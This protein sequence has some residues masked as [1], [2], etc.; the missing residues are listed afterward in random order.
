MEAVSCSETLESFY[1]ITRRFIP[2][3]SNL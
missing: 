3:D 1:Q 2:K